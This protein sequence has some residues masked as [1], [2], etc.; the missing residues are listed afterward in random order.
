MSIFDRPLHNDMDVLIRLI[1]I[2]DDTALAEAGI[3]KIMERAGFDT[4]SLGYLASQ[5]AMRALG[6]TTMGEIQAQMQEFVRL[7]SVYHEAFVL[8]MWFEQDR[9]Q[10]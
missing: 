4:G 3:D 9:G 1:N 6:I 2:L 7:A 8:G 5:R 10:G